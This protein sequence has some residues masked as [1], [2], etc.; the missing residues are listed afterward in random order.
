MAGILIATV[1]MMVIL[2]S[3][4]FGVHER[5]S[6]RRLVGLVIGLVGVVTLL[7]LDSWTECSGGSA[8]LHRD[9]D[10]GLCHWLIDRAASP[11]GCR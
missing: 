9:R 11:V 7:G 10:R 6:A 4:L 2:L 8:W 5:L 3:P 1:P